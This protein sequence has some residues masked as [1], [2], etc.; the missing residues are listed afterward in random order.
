MQLFIRIIFKNNYHL[1]NIFFLII[2]KNYE[3]TIANQI[4]YKCNVTV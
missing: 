4:F 3:K 1:Y 2:I